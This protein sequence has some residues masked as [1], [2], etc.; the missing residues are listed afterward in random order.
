MTDE[1]PDSRTLLANERTL[2]AWVRTALALQAAGVGV[3][4]F[5]TQIRARAVIGLV[6]VALGAATGALGYR[7]Y[8]QVDRAIRRGQVLPRAVA[9]DAVV[10]A[11]VVLGIVLAAAA[12]TGRLS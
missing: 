11:V 3:L 8:R 6:L 12:L 5:A 2:L 4:Q 7:R 10:L 1:A 9:P